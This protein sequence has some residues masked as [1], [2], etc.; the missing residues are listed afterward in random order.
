MAFREL[1]DDELH[2]VTVSRH[3]VPAPQERA[4]LHPWELERVIRYMEAN[5]LEPLRTNDLAAIVN[6][7][8]GRF[9]ILFRRTVGESPAAYLRRR[10]IERAQELM[11]VGDASLAT[12]ASACGLAD[13]AHLTRLFRRL[14]GS[15]PAKWR[16]EQRATTS[17]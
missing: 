3:S 7:S 11:L 16:R 15:S 17:P 12:I 2:F 10:R 1:H 6:R 5:L 14:V 13:Q 4:A 8:A 9:T